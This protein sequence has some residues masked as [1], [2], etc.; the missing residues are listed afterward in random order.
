MIPGV[1]SREFWLLLTHSGFLMFRTFLSVYIASLDGQIVGHLV[2]KNGQKF[3]Q[4][5]IWWMTIAIPAT[6]TNAMVRP[7]FAAHSLLTLV[8]NRSPLSRASLRFASARA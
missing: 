2:N 6:Y 1:K 7:A 3:T 4:G 8:A 5:I